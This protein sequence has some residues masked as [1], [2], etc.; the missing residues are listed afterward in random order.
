MTSHRT[1]PVQTTHIRTTKPKVLTT[2]L[3][4]ISKHTSA[5]YLQNV[6][7]QSMT[8]PY[9]KHPFRT[10]IHRTSRRP[11]RTTSSRPH[12]TTS[13]RPHTTKKSSILSSG[14]GYFSKMFSFVKAKIFKDKN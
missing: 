9:D 8:L 12:H 5:P 3:L 11:H 1:T 6:Y 4:I 2:R 10:S 7:S 13:S 14:V